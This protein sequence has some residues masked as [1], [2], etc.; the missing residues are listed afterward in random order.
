MSTLILIFN[1]ITIFWQI[2]AKKFKV[3]LF[4]GKL[5]PIVSRGNWFLFR[6]WFSRFLI[7]KNQSSSFLPENWHTWCLG[8]ADS[9]SGLICLKFLPTIYFLSKFFQKSI[10]WFMFVPVFLGHFVPFWQ[11]L[12]F[13]VWCPFT[14]YS[15]DLRKFDPFSHL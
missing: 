1:L 4:A 11:V 14:T 10:F 7:L 13:W 12:D 3:A 8:D 5:A 6:H 15:K 9:E 2:R